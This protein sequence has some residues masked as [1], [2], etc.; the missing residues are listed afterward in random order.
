M[1]IGYAITYQYFTSVNYLCSP[2]GLNTADELAV[3][4]DTTAWFT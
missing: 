1:V 3:F 4:M 2:L